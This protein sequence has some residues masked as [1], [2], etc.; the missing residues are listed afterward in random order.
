MRPDAAMP[1]GTGLTLG[2]AVL[3]ASL[4]VPAAEAQLRAFPAIKY[5][6]LEASDPDSEHLRQDIGAWLRARRR[7]VGTLDDV[8]PAERRLFARC[9]VRTELPKPYALS[10]ECVD[11][12]GAFVG[13]KRFESSREWRGWLSAQ[14]GVVH[15]D[16]RPLHTT[17][18]VQVDRVAGRYADERL[19][20]RSYVEEQLR[21]GGLTVIDST[22]GL[23]SDDLTER[24]LRFSIRALITSSG[25]PFVTSRGSS[26]VLIDASGR[27]VRHFVGSTDAA[28]F[29]TTAAAGRRSL[30]DAVNRFLDARRED[31]EVYQR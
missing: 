20:F 24:Y 12:A 7:L 30:R 9:V 27:T 21:A 29:L 19:G 26:I 31:A 2:A 3:V 8:K 16:A 17:R 15:D 23:S 28:M 25:E 14:L 13:A 6:L 4:L 5:M 18:F 11:A 22:E 10:L 1:L